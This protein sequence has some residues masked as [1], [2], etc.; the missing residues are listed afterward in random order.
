MTQKKGDI[1]G[2]LKVFV[3]GVGFWGW[4]VVGW[5]GKMHKMRI[6]FVK[7]FLWVKIDAK[8]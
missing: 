5:E 4:G 7:D 1:L 8:K 3:L 6:G 2:K